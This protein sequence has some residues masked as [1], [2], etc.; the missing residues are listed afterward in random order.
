MVFLLHT[1]IVRTLTL[2]PSLLAMVTAV[3]RSVLVWR[4]E[5]AVDIS[6]RR[7]NPQSF[8][9]QGW[10]KNRLECTGQIS[11]RLAEDVQAT[12]FSV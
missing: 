1:C 8:L 9:R 4:S 11:R 10:A 3:P 6:V 7:A 2:S 12:G 5:R